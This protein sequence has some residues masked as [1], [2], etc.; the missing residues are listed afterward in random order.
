MRLRQKVLQASGRII[1]TANGSRKQRKR[2]PGK[3][4]GEPGAAHFQASSLK[5]LPKPLGVEQFDFTV[6]EAHGDLADYYS[7]IGRHFPFVYFLIY[8][9]LRM[10][11]AALPESKTTDLS[12]R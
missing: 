5:F 6:T 9:C 10:F 7:N 11:S 3:D 8:F 12:Y 4:L 1:Q 2:E